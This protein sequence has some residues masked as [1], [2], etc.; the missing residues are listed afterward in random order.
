MKI[1]LEL[2]YPFFLECCKYSDDIFWKFIFED[3]AYGKSP[4]GTYI[5]KNFLC[6]NYKDK[7]FSYKIDPKKDPKIIYENI[8]KLL[9]NKFGL[10]SQIDKNNRR[11]IFENTKNNIEQVCK[12]DW[13]LIKKKNIK[14]I[15]IENFVID[16]KNKY[17][18]SDK[19]CKKLL[20]IIKIGIIFKTITKEDINYNNGKIHDIKNIV[21]SNKKIKF[22][23]NIYKTNNIKLSSQIIIEKKISM[24][25][26]WDKHLLNLKKK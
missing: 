1:R 4:Y 26:N 20:S 19:L 23:K 11:H 12:T 7:Q 21:F 14:N 10:M 9:F 24:S 17:N 5:T 8:H 3:L 22:N 16:M 2:V 25:D 18:L 6:C 13:N 15:L